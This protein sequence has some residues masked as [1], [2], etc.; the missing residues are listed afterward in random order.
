[1]DSRLGARC[2]AWRS[3]AR[4]NH[5]A[6]YRIRALVNVD[7]AQSFERPKRLASKLRALLLDQRVRF[8][9]VGGINTVVGFA[10]FVLVDLTV[11]RAVDTSSNE[12][13][14]SVVTLAVSQVISVMIAFV[15]HRRFV[16]RVRGQV[17]LDFVRFQGVYAVTFLINLVTLPLLVAIGVPRLIAQAAIVVAMTFGSYLAHRHFSFR[18]TPQPSAPSPP[19]NADEAR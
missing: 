19:K 10:V 9:I 11:G 14:G 13:F 12:A 7:S 18:R 3:R 8:V 17:W 5:S 2:S 6:D 15:L 1:V 16:F 4:R